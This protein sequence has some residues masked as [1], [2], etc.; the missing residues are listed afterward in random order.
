MAKGTSDFANQNTERAVQATSFGM[1]WMREIAEQNLD[2]SKVAMDGF[3]MIA[4]KAL[5]GIDQQASVICK[6]SMLFAEQTLSNTFDFAH[7]LL[8]MKEPQELVK[9]QS[10]FVS[11]QAQLA[12]DQTKE[13]GQRVAELNDMTKTTLDGAAEH[14]R[15]RFEAA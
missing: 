3:F 13:F 6:T 1:N 5:D 14:V 2:Q 11:R 9:L 12:G 7:K 15:R 10:D 4:R 8:R